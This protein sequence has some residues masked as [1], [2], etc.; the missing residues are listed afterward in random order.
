MTLVW[1]ELRSRHAPPSPT[2]IIYMQMRGVGLRGRTDASDWGEERRRQAGTGTP[3][4]PQSLG[5]LNG[6]RKH[7]E[8]SCTSAIIHSSAIIHYDSSTLQRVCRV[9][10][11]GLEYLIPAPHHHIRITV[12]RLPESVNV[13]L[14]CQYFYR[15]TVFAPVVE[16]TPPDSCIHPPYRLR[17]LFGGGRTESGPKARLHKGFFTRTLCRSLGEEHNTARS[18]QGRLCPSRDAVLAHKADAQAHTERFLCYCEAGYTDLD[19]KKQTHSIRRSHIGL[20]L[21]DNYYYHHLSFYPPSFIIYH[22]AIALSSII[23]LT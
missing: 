16:P 14:M 22:L 19:I 12:T 9:V 15:S 23:R 3:R 17:E 2:W 7:T 18:A 6:Q 13:R 21:N 10:R 1:F 5:S 20:Y 8:F 4:S 11:H